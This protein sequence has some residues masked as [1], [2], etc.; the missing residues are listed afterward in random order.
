MHLRIHTGERPFTCQYCNEK[1]K[2]KSSLQGH[3]RIHTGEKPYACKKCN[4][5]FRRLDS[6]KSHEMRKKPCDVMKIDNKVK[7]NI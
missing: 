6:L 5:V 3:V 1:F 2:Q 4:K 7:K